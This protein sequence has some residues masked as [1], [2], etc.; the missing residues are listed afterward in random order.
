M[1]FGFGNAGTIERTIRGFPAAASFLAFRER[2]G[3]LRLSGERFIWIC[4]E[5]SDAM[6]HPYNGQADP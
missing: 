1:S 2:M 6:H 3:P 4:L 5:E